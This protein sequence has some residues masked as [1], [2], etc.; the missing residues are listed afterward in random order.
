MENRQRKL[1]LVAAALIAPLLAVAVSRADGPPGQP[2]TASGSLTL[3]AVTVKLTHAYASVQPGFFDKKTEDTRVLLSDVPL[4]DAALTDV[5]ELIHLARDGK[6]HVVEVDI[7]A[8]G[9]PI[10]GGLFAKNFDG[11][12]SAAGMHKFAKDRWDRTLIAGRLWVDGPQEFMNVKWH[13]DA[14]FSA[15]IPRPSKK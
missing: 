4:P 6:V 8:T 2:G 15:S 10:G 12:V 3:D 11:T 14:T 9:T 13:Y 1:A 5:F 7:D